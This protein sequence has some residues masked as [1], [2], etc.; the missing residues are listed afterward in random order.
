MESIYTKK[1]EDTPEITLDK[2]KGIFSITGN[3]YPDDPVEVYK[4]AVDWLKEYVKSP[5]DQTIFDLQF[6]YMN[7]SSSKQVVDMM[8]I[9]EEIPSDKEV[10]VNWHYDKMDE[11][12]E[13]E[14]ETLQSTVNV[15][16]ELIGF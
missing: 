11:D 3:S 13:F 4:P 14:G 15:K 2:E 10:I 1:T 7:T 5:N 9:L 12:M 16:I 8:S 6:S